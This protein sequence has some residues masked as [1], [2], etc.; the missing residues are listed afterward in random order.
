MYLSSPPIL[1]LS[2]CKCYTFLLISIVLFRYKD[3]VVC[4]KQ[5]L[6]TKDP[7]TGLPAK[8][9][10]KVEKVPPTYSPTF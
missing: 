2:L 3:Q 4:A 10:K 7:S 1:P 6:T 9:K 8:K 5:S